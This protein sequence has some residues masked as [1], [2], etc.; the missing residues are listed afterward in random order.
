MAWDYEGYWNTVIGAHLDAEGAVREF[1]LRPGDITGFKSW[2]DEAEAIAW[3]QGGLRGDRP[4]EWQGF[5]ARAAAELQRA[6]GE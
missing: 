2:L 5:Q 6:A 3:Q 1:D 4:G